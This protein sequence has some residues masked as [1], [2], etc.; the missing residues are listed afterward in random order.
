[1]NFS[2]STVYI[3]LLLWALA[4]ACEG[5][6]DPLDP[7]GGDGATTPYDDGGPAA[8]NGPVVPVVDWTSPAELEQW[9]ALYGYRGRIQG[10]NTDQNELWLMDP[11]GAN[12]VQL[13]NLKDGDG[14]DLSCN[15]GCF[16]NPDLTWIAVV[17][18][19]PVASGFEFG[20][21]PISTNLEAKLIK[22]VTFKDVIDFKFAGSR[23]FYSKTA[24]CLGPSCQYDIFVRD[25]DGAGMSEVWLGAFPPEYD[26][27][28]STYKGHFR[29]NKD[30]TRLAMLNTTIRS[31]SVYAWLD[32]TGFIELDYICKFGSKGNCSGTG[33]EYNDKD[34]IAVSDDGRWVVFFTFSDRWQRIRLYDLEDPSSIALTIAASVPSGAYIEKACDPGN[35][36]GWQWQ[37][38][39]GDPVFTSN[40]EEIVFLTEFNCPILDAVACPGG[41]ACTPQKR[42]TNLRR[43]KLDTLKKGIT[44]AEE[45]QFNITN[46]PHGDIA[47]NRRVSGFGVSPD[48]ATILFTA[49]PTIDQNGNFLD[50]GS[51]RQRNDRELFRV[52]LDGENLLQLTNELSWLA[53]SPRI[54]PMV[55]GD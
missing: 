34:P 12:K 23:I 35:I 5:D 30:G 20:I 52:R 29:V 36:Q 21:G 26:L 53:E 16:V 2:K 49:S 25:L 3:C 51:S 48:S 39:I 54:A 14:Y 38:V 15:Y 37:R 7:N 18:A 42:R 4:C 22:G 17:T 10:V 43:I 40:N 47:T 55:Q 33:S 50:D 41:E 27:E 6:P 32:G 44:L 46:N 8:D 11:N 31:V 13:T 1:M 24:N 28:D 9:R 19:P 45:D